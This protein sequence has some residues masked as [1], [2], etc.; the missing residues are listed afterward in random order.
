MT[1]I[2]PIL[3]VPLMIA[4]TL[5]S[6]VSLLR[7]MYKVSIVSI[8]IAFILNIITESIPCNIHSCSYDYD[9]RLMT[10]NIHEI[11]LDP[12]MFFDSCARFTNVITAIDADVVCLQEFYPWDKS[13]FDSILH[14]HYP[15]RAD[16]KMDSF[17]NLNAIYSRYPIVNVGS[18]NT[19]ELHAQTL[20]AHIQSPNG[21]LTVC[22]CHLESNGYDEHE[23]STIF[24]IGYM[25]DKIGDGGSS[26]EKQSLA[27]RRWIDSCMLTNSNIIVCGDMND[28]SG[29]KTLKNIQGRGDMKNAW[30]ERGSWLG[31]T[32]RGRWYMPF[33]LDHILYSDG[34]ECTSVKVV[35]QN[36]SDH[37]PVVADFK[38]V[39]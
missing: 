32:Y 6:V 23:G 2:F 12:Y 26:R 36:F 24:D 37:D 15:Y 35:N 34:L 8:V 20:T 13:S 21:V 17:E 25:L 31:V 4:L 1:H 29:S 7:R 16:Y 39:K 38:F 3:I 33:R 27:V 14:D 11:G 19:K 18:V 30:W 5:L 28:F 10:F 22:D 9:F